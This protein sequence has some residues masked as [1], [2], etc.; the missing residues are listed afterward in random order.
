M[1][2]MAIV[3][4]VAVA[5]LY[6]LVGHGTTGS[7]TLEQKLA[8]RADAM[9]T[10]LPKRL[11]NGMTLSAVTVEG[12]ALTFRVTGV[13]SWSSL[14]D[15]DEMTRMYSHILCRQSGVADIVQEGGTV[16]FAMTDPTGTSLPS[17]IVRHCPGV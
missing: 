7:R 2:M 12:K 3:G 15:Q 10:V 13:P 4:G 17:V 14:L 6:P 1:R 11:A 5:A 16:R 8:D 9:S